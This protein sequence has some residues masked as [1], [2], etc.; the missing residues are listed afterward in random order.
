MEWNHHCLPLLLFSRQG[1]NTTASTCS[2]E[3]PPL[4]VMRGRARIQTTTSSSTVWGSCQDTETETSVRH[5]RDP[6]LAQVMG[7]PQ[8][9]TEEPKF[10]QMQVCCY[11][12]SVLLGSS[13]PEA[14]C[15]RTMLRAGHIRPSSKKKKKKQQPQATDSS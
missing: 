10:W 12:H 11:A 9:L 7:T 14:S 13:F 15:M 4:K 2:K 3:G 5:T 8:E 6:D 1:T